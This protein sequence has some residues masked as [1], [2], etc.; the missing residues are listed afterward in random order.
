MRETKHY[1]FKLTDFEQPLL[2][3]R[4]R[5]R[6]LAV[7]RSAVHPEL[8]GVRAQGPAHNQ[9]H[10]LG[11]ARS[12]P[13]DG[14]TR[15]STSGSRRSSVTCRP[16]RNGP[17]ASARPD[18]WKEYLDGSRGQELL[19][20]GQGQHSVPHHH[21]AF[22]TDGLRRSQP[23][24]RRAGQRVPDLQGGEALQEQGA[25]SIDIPSILKTLRRRPGALLPGDQHAGGQGRRLL[26][27]G[28]RDQG[29]QRA[30]GH[31]RQLLPPGASASPRRTSRTVPPLRKGLETETQ[32]GGRRHRRRPWSRW[33]P[34]SPPASSRRG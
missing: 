30:G 21:L 23:P 2:S 10:V 19:L 4:P 33:T 12:A 25:V 1:F 29:Q 31:A 27:G 32:A 17:R 18:A 20:P 22:H 15:S 34:T 24:L 11:R 3:L 9:G 5:K 16:A 14:R 26:L 28:L 13:G 7:Q 6:S 8:A